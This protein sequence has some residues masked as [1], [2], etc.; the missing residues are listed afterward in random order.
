MRACV[1]RV[2]V[3]LIRTTAVTWPWPTPAWRVWSSWATIWA[4]SIKRRVWR[5]WE[6]CSWRTA[7]PA[8]PLRLHPC[9]FA[10]YERVAVFALQLLL[11]PRRQW[12]R[13]EVRVLCRLHLLHAGRL[14]W[15]GLPESHRLHQEK[16]SESHHVPLS[17][18]SCNSIL[19]VIPKHSPPDLQGPAEGSMM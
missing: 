5:A 12:E 1:C 2:P 6:R 10:V 9:M 16:H 17:S 4:A 13:H 19:A 15:D 18:F 7:G 3:R 8:L 11:R 14:V